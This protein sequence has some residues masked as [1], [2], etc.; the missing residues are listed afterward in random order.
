[1]EKI[2]GVI[3][4]GGAASRFGGKTKAN[5]IVGGISIIS[6]MVN[7]LNEIFDEIIIVTNRPEEFQD[8]RNYKVVADEHKN[9][10]PLGGIH[11]A[12]T[13]SSNPA[14]FVFA[15]DMPFISGDLIIRQIEYFNKSQC[16]VL[17]PK[18]NSK[19]EPLHAIYNLTT[20]LKL[21]YFLLAMNDYAIRNF[22]GKVDV[23]YWHLEET[24]VYRKVFTNINTPSDLSMADKVFKQN[25]A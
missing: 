15:G 17:I 3:L 21:D 6:R 16:D 5:M 24:P 19:D 23:T 1:V 18:I 9:T 12:M 25:E 13:V 20:F 22:L 14:I 11:A 2:S 10:G 7:T 4:A 8:Y